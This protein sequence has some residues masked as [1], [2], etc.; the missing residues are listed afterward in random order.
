MLYV[1]I[2]TTLNYHLNIFSSLVVMTFSLPSFGHNA[3]THVEIT[4]CTL[5]ILSLV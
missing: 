4:A 2:E 5:I 3:V 1:I